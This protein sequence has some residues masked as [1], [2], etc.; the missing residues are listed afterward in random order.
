MLVFK[1]FSRFG[2]L[3]RNKG[4]LLSAACIASAV[5]TQAAL[6]D[7]SWIVID[8]DSGRVL[9]QENANSLHAP[10]SLAKMMTLYL[11]FE[12]LKTGS[13]K[14]EDR[15][16]VSQNASRKVPMKLWLKAGDTISVKEAVDGMIVISANDAATVVGEYMAGS[17]AAFAKLM[18]R[19]GRQ[20]GLKSTVF[21]NPSGLTAPL[22]QLTTARDMAT[23]GTALKRDFPE[24]YPLIGQPSFVF[25]GKLLK[26]HNNLMYR[27]AGVDGIKT[28]Y[29][30]VSGYN[31]VSSLS[32][33]NRHLVGVVMGGKTARARDDQ[34]AALLTRF[35]D[36]DVGQ[37]ADIVAIPADKPPISAF[38]ADAP[39]SDAVVAMNVSPRINS[40]KQGRLRRAAIGPNTVGPDTVAP[41]TVGPDTVGNAINDAMIEQGDGG[42]ILP[43][44]PATSKAA[45]SIQVGAVP[46]R[47]GAQKLGQ[48]AKTM[49]KPLPAGLKVVV[50]APNPN[51]TLFS[52]RLTG[53]SDAKSADTA[54]TQ[55]KKQ[56]QDCFVVI[57]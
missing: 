10:A 37:G 36:T 8:S 27:Y 39:P 41:D 35:S 50:E 56:K 40:G 49:L 45:W 23:L 28:G 21:A 20:I 55:L 17:E 53:F 12:A 13:L 3:W 34:M 25:R 19:R 57:P 1:R 52:A 42:T 32:R 29:T 5:L 24:N 47:A 46:T 43:G 48:T 33:N 18:T 4:A 26:G 9:G 44:Q 14:W 30:D 22:S 54:C 51:A 7:N 16:P 38:T 31:L 6:A 11:T 15:I 2:R